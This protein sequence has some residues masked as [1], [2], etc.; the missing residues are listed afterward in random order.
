M[1]KTI[2]YLLAII[3]LALII[4]VSIEQSTIGNN[5]KYI[6][7]SVISAILL[8]ILIILKW[9]FKNVL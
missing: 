4:G 9:G 7:L 5:K 3:I 6:L 8:N 1:F 2:F